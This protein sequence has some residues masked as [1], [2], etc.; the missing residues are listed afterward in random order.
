MHRETEGKGL[1]IHFYWGGV[2]ADG[3]YVN[4]LLIGKQEYFSLLIFIF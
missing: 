4:D 1:L 3:S 2:T